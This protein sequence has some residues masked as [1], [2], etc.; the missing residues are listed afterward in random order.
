MSNG[1]NSIRKIFQF[2][3]VENCYLSIILVGL[4]FKPACGQSISLDI[5]VMLAQVY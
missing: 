5:R 2:G 3:I 4:G 1:I